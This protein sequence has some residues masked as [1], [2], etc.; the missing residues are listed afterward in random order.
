MSVEFWDWLVKRP[1]KKLLR[2]YTIGHSTRRPEEFLSLLKEFGISVVADIRR[3]PSSRKFPHFNGPALSE[4][5]RAANMQYMWLEQ[6]GGRRHSSQND[7]SPNLG[8]KSPGL[9]SYADHMATTEF[10]HGVKRLLSAAATSP[11]AVMC[12][13]KLFWKCHRRLLSDYLV[14][15]NVEV[16]HIMESGGVQPHRLSR[17]AVITGRGEVI[18][19]QPNPAENSQRRLFE[20]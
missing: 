2:V 15:R 9:R 18:Y 16:L 14:A 8:L 10:R 4:L 11:T 6:L 20:P 13:E 12:A 17:G 19:P 1:V 5:L 7:Q 3:Y